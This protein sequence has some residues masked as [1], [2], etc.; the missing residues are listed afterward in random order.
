MITFRNK[1][2][3][4]I[5]N[6][7]FLRFAWLIACMVCLTSC[8][9]KHYDMDKIDAT[10]GVGGDN[11][12]LYGN[13]STNGIPLEDIFEI[14]GSVFVHVKDDGTYELTGTNT[15]PFN[16]STSIDPITI[17]SSITREKEIVINLKDF[18]EKESSKVR[19]R[20]VKKEVTIERT[21]ANLEY[22]TT[23]IPE[24]ISELRYVN[25]EATMHMRMTFNEN[26]VQVLKKLAEVKFTMPT[27]IDVESIVFEGQP[28]TMD[29]TNT[30][31]LRDV[32]PPSKGYAELDITLKGMD[33]TKK[34][35]NNYII[36]EK[37]KRLYAK[38]EV[39]IS[40]T[41][42][43]EDVN[44]F[45]LKEPYIF[46][47]MCSANI[48]DTKIT[49]CIG[50]FDINYDRD[51]LG[52]LVVNRYP[53]FLDDPDVRLK[54]YD[55]HIN[56]NYTNDLP[57]DG[58]VTGRLVASD[59]FRYEFAVMDVPPFV[60]KG[61]GSG[62]ISLRRIPAESHGDT[63]VVVIPNITD[64]INILPCKVELVDVKIT[65]ASTGW[66][67]LKFGHQYSSH[68]YYT[69]TNSLALAEGAQIVHNDTLK[70]MH[71][72]VKDLRFKE[73]NENGVSKIDG[74]VQMDADVENKIPAYIKVTAHGIDNKGDSISTD[75]LNF[76]M[77]KV[78]PAS[79]DGVTP[80]ECHITIIGKATDNEVFKT[81]DQIK[82]HMIGSAN[83]ENGQNPVTG[84]PINALKQTVRLKNIVI[85]KHGKLIGDFN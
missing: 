60:M 55:P 49:G 14:E 64:V 68:T 11:F 23:N 19:A 44:V 41:V 85:K 9:D 45:Y 15:T 77:D 25:T 28:C 2:V 54:L 73:I 56:L 21:V 30:F 35:K 34:D 31:T 38:G 8:I 48:S 6:R 20:K 63:T 79:K 29:E 84:I 70:Q 10:V 61:K 17:S 22:E 57:V 59:R 47:A 74:Y 24:E 72:W 76:T 52:K 32:V 42:K 27:F 16:M 40:G 46:S 53:V 37:G 58:L 78:V 82:F 62:V 26:V 75:R 13:N 80:S 39:V 4:L 81:L 43:L 69:L 3:K 67:E 50:K 12:T 18:S 66:T 7:Y 51:I 1:M 71:D 36:F 65:N 83:D 5:Y 33:L